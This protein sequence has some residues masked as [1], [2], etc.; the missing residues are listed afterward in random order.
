MNLIAQ[1]IFP[2]LILEKKRIALKKLLKLC[3]C[4]P[5]YYGITLDIGGFNVDQINIDNKRVDLDSN[6]INNILQIEKELRFDPLFKVIKTAKTAKLDRELYAEDFLEELDLNS[7]YGTKP[8]STWF[9]VSDSNLRYYIKELQSDY[10]Y[11]ENSPSFNNSFRFKGIAVIK[12]WMIMQ[13]KDEY[14]MKGLNRLISGQELGFPEVASVPVDL[15]KL[16]TQLEGT[17]RQLALSG[18][19]TL[20]QNESGNHLVLNKNLDRV[21]NQS[22][23]QEKLKE[24]EHRAAIVQGEL[25]NENLRLE[26]TEDRLK[27]LKRYLELMELKFTPAKNTGFFSKLFKSSPETPSN[28]SMNKEAAE[29]IAHL[30]DRR[31]IVQETI[32]TKN[33]ELKNIK[34]EIS[35]LKKL[36]EANKGIEFDSLKIES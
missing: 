22:E 8:I 24:L 30:E 33:L 1:K 29:D 2:H 7:H 23:E 32:K 15:K 13:L 12:L 11:E 4:K 26:N 14:K 20:E 34:D 19:F 5:R 9:N 31:T 10:L 18:I 6:L 3:Y 36:I 16:E 25:N 21:L 28:T 35:T 17:I 27:D